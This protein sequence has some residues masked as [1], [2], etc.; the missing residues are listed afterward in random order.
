VGHDREKLEKEL[1]ARLSRCLKLA[2]EYPHGPT[3]KNIHELE[4]EIR[5]Q[6]EQLDR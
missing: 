3:N 6:L 2:L 1:R 4:A 5:R